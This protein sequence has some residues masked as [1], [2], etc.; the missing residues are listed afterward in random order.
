MEQPYNPRPEMRQL[1]LNKPNLNKADEI[2]SFRWEKGK[3]DELL[4]TLIDFANDK[5]ISFDWYDAAVLSEKVA[6]D[7]QATS[8]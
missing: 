4:D 5:R 2:Y 1:I 3:E 8:K 6:Q 7:K